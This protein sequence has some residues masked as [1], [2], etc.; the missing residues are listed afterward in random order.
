MSLRPKKSIVLAV[1]AKKLSYVKEGGWCDINIF[2]AKRLGQWPGLK[3][4]IAF[5][6]QR[7]GNHSLSVDDH[8]RNKKIVA[9]FSGESP[10]AAVWIGLNAPH[11]IRWNL[12]RCYI[13]HATWH[14]KAGP[15]GIRCAKI[16][17]ILNCV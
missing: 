15:R 6:V 16:E 10:Y 8:E 13:P 4:L 7:H 9:T 17:K 12:Q 14:S 11:G 3:F 1:Q 2:L 5:N